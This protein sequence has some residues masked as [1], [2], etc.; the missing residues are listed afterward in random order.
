MT[1]FFDPDNDGRATVIKDPGARLD[2]VWDLRDW[3]ADVSDAVADYDVLVSGGL[4]RQS[5]NELGGVVTAWLSGGSVGA[6]ASA[7]CRVTTAGGRIDERTIWF[8]IQER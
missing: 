3:L 2:Y 1:I 8:R 7:T 6:E 5:Q 4:V